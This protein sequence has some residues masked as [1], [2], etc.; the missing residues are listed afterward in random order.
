MENSIVAFSERMQSKLDKNKFKECAAMNPDGMGRDWGRCSL[1]W[2]LFR[3]REETLELEQALR[4]DDFE[5]AMD[6]AADV[7]NFAMMIHDN[8]KNKYFQTDSR[9]R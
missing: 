5:N 8:L 1:Y 4:A 9:N 7:G 2:L 6:E 3:L